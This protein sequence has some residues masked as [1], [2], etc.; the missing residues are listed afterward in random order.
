MTIESSWQMIGYESK[1]IP[2]KF[3]YQKIVLMVKMVW[4]FLIRYGHD[5]N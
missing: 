1:L 3:D 5:N 4:T 2:S